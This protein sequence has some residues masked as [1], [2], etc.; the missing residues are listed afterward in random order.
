M[1]PILAIVA[2]GRSRKFPIPFPLI[3][4]WPFVLLGF[5][6]LGLAW[7]FLPKKSGAARYVLMA[8]TALGCFW[9]LSGLRID[10]NSHDETDVYILIV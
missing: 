7:F 9:H 2:I 5:F 4:L 1:P 6:V 8:I 10:I 3:L